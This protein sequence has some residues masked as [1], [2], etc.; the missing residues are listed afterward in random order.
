LENKPPARPVTKALEGYIIQLSFFEKGE[1][2]RW[3]ENL[4]GRGFAVSMTEA[5]GSGAFRVRIGNFPGR[6]EAERQLKTLSQEGLKGIV[7]NL[8]Q[9][10]HPEV[11]SSTEALSERTSATP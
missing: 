5:G 8:P 10:Y 2:Q 4:T 3:A 1:A 11:R 9:A 6:S 7:L